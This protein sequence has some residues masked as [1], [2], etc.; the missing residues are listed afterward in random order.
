MATSL[1]YFYQYAVSSYQLLNIL[2][3]QPHEAI[4]SCTCMK[5]FITYSYKVLLSL[6]GIQY[7]NKILFLGTP[8]SYSS[9][10][11]QF[12]HS[13]SLS[14]KLHLS[15]NCLLTA[16]T[17]TVAAHTTCLQALVSAIRISNSFLLLPATLFLTATWLSHSQPWATVERE[18][19]P[20]LITAFLTYFDPKVT[21]SLVSLISYLQQVV[22]TTPCQIRYSLLYQLLLST[23]CFSCYFH[24]FLKGNIITYSHQLLATAITIRFFYLLLISTLLA[25]PIK[26]S[27]QNSLVTTQYQYSSHTLRLTVLLWHFG[28]GK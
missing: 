4:V 16:I 17:V 7:H 8:I 13:Q 27:Y 19:Y 5:S 20:V 1:I 25:T 11:I 3:R 21:R 15:T 10:T 28:T 6:T 14:Y 12:F 22:F 23:S 18:P 26:C 24:V 2:I 9:V